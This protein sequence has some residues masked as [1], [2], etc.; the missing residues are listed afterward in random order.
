[1]SSKIQRNSDSV[2]Y[3]YG[4]KLLIFILMT[5]I[6]AILYITMFHIKKVEVV[7]ANR[8]TDNQIKEL[9]FQDEMDYNSL[10]LTLK[11]RFFETPGLPFVEKIDITM[12]NNHEITIYVYEKVIAGCI[13]FMGEYLYFDKDGIVVESSS[14]RLN[15]IPLIKGLKFDQIILNEKL[16]LQQK[17]EIQ[18]DLKEADS[19]EKQLEQEEREEQLFQT[20]INLT[21]L[22]EK[23][24]LDINTISFKNNNEISLGYENITILLGNRKVYDEPIAQLE[25]ILDKAKGM[26]ITIDMRNYNN[27]RDHIIAKPKKTS[28]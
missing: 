15:D 3:R 1:M 12:V 23:Y 27:E 11:Y 14:K 26:E 10:F 6:P 25:S 2:R 19:E 16:K 24:E 22:I 8:Y 9:I 7:G 13:E 20:M 21:Q 18:S 5:G 28:K 17:D 4:K